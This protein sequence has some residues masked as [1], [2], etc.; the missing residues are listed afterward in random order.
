MKA[1]LIAASKL[2]KNIPAEHYGHADDI[3]RNPVYITFFR[4]YQ[5]ILDQLK[6][7][8]DAASNKKLLVN[9]YKLL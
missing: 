4:D 9:K 5:S 2:T 8:R 1:T 3:S 6:N 7:K